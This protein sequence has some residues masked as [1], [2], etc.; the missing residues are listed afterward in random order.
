MKKI[1]NLTLSIGMFFLLFILFHASEGAAK[2]AK[3]ASIGI[4]E[5]IGTEQVGPPWYDP[6]WNYRCP[7]TINNIAGD[8]LY[9]QV[10]V[11]LTSTN[12]DFSKA[13][14]DGSDLRITQRDGIT[15]LYHWVESWNSTSQWAYVWVRVPDLNIGNKTIYLYYNNPAATTTPFKNG[16]TTF[17]GFDDS[18]S[19]F[20]GAGFNLE[21]T[22]S[23]Q[24]PYEVNSQFVW[25]TINGMPSASN[26]IL[27]LVNAI[28]IKSTPP[29]QFNE[30]VAMGFRAMYGSG[31]GNGYGGFINGTIGSRTMIGDYQSYS[32]DLY[33][34]NYVNAYENLALPRVGG[35][36]WHNAYHVYELRWIP[37]KTRGDV[38]HDASNAEST[39]PAQV[40][41]ATLPV[42]LYSYSGSNA[43]LSVDWVYVRQ[44]RN[45]EPIATINKNDQ[46]G[47]V[48]LGVTAVDSPDP[49]SKYTELTYQLT[50]SNTS[51][52]AA[53]GVIVTDTLPGSVQFV[54]ANP[55]LGC[56]H[57]AGEVVC[58]LNTIAANSFESVTIVVNPTLDGVIT[59]T[60]TVGSPGFELDM[61]NNIGQAVTLVDS[62]P[63]SVNWESPVH[64]GQKYTTNGGWITL[65][66]SA[67]DNN[68][69][70]W[71]EFW[72]WNHINPIGKISIG[73]DNTYPYQMQFDS[74]LLV[75]NEEYQ[76]FVQATDRAG[77]TSDIYTAPYP[78]IY[79]KRISLYFLYLPI[80]IK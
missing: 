14:V 34:R 7:V 18:W 61:S 71:V 24:S 29:H 26:G 52:I 50:I 43:T 27:N 48:N 69:V 65:E 11:T 66:A 59:N 3:S 68:Q 9:Y 38:D 45:P 30:Y 51:N 32:Y 10:L 54:R 19:Q 20:S 23:P 64:N 70:A 53:P 58:N 41:S 33:L 63:P 62:V 47:L 73:T 28:G 60:V 78:V 40:P 1:F 5:Q 72:Y 15:E 25:S 22:Q 42:T 80:A 12:F 44:Y 35:Y 17:D 21:E 2:A 67:T 57:V 76:V 56:S 4:E 6:A 77:N 13:K 8:L 16:A 55:P 49:I 79:F 36:D 74:D 31:D 39:D 75:S 37:G 46:Q